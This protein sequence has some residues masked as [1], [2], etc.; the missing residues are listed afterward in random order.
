[1]FRRGK[2][3]ETESRLVIVRRWEFLGG[4]GT[5]WEITAHSYRVS[6]GG[7]RKCSNIKVSAA[8]SHDILKTIEL[9]PFNE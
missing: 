6:F 3:T 1:M 8:Q 7:Q 5:E 9:Y 2:S 4:E